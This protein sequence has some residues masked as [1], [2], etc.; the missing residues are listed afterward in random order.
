[1]PVLLMFIL[2]VGFLKGPPPL[3]MQTTLPLFFLDAPIHFL[4]RALFSLFVFFIMY[5]CCVLLLIM[6]CVCEVMWGAESELQLGLGSVVSCVIWCWWTV[7]GA[8]CSQKALCFPVCFMKRHDTF[9]FILANIFRDHLWQV[10]LQLVHFS[11]SFIYFAH[12]AR[13]GRYHIQEIV[14][15]NT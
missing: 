15:I 4:T 7:F 5:Y 11:D 2:I 9:F 6:V 13:S 12:A 8:P 1:M 14:R 10:D 3:V